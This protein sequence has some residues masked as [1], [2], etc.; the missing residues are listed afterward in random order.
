MIKV[1]VGFFVGAL[2]G[3]VPLV[4]G[5]LSKMYLSSILGIVSTALSGI[6]FSVL[7]KSPFTSV[8]VAIV[9]LVI[10]FAQRKKKNAD[11]DIDEHDEY[12]DDE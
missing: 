8:G 1:L 10:I 9:F 7:D 6:V 12:M 3:I 5:L 4:F 11:N 2:C